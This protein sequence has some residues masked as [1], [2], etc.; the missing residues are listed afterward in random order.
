MNGW[1]K[2]IGDSVIIKYLF[3]F[4]GSDKVMI[5]RILERAKKSGR[6]DDNE[7]TLKKRIGVFRNET[8]V[9]IQQYE[10]KGIVKKVK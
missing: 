10:K 2:I 5:Q 3:F 8:M 1:E 9:I 4:E 6:T 7:E